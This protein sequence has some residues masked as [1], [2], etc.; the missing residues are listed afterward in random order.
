LSLAF[1]RKISKELWVNFKAASVL[2]GESANSFRF[3]SG[4]SFN[5]LSSGLVIRRGYGGN[6][7]GIYGGY[8]GKLSRSLSLRIDGEWS[9]FSITSF[10]LE[11]NDNS[12]ALSLRTGI[13]LRFNRRV[14]IDGE[15][16][17]LSQSIEWRNIADVIPF[18]GNDRE[19]R[20][21]VKLNLWF[22]KGPGY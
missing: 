20:V 5:E 8:Y 19:L 11:D 12:S 17:S 4:V 9:D 10:D 7:I 3:N 14:S 15:L 1:D 6:W 21:F 18:A 2:Y 16:Q 13:N 22:F